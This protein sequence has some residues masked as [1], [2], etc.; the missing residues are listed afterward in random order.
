MDPG[1]LLRAA[2]VLATA[3]AVMA[4]C[5]NSVLRQERDDARAS[6]AS[7]RGGSE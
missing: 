7:C 4:M 2:L 6:V 3:V 5:D 1:F